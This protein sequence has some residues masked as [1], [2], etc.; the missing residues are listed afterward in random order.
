MHHNHLIKSRDIMHNDSQ[1]PQYIM[2]EVVIETY[3]P[4]LALYALSIVNLES[5]TITKKQ[6]IFLMM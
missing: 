3:G 6:K 1:S 2:D 5:L 4:M